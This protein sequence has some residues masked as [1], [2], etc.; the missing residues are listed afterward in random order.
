MRRIFSI[1]LGLSLLICGA[2][3]AAAQDATDEKKPVELNG[4]VVEYSVDGNVVTASGNVVIKH[5]QADMYCDTVSFDRLNNIANAKGN[6]RLVT[7]QGEITANELTFDFK[8]MKG[9]FHDARIYAE[10]YYGAAR[11]ISRVSESKIV[12]EDGYVTTSDF[13]KPE[14]RMSSSR[15]EI[16]PKDKIIAKH[17]RLQV[18]PMPLV[19]LPYFRQRLDE[20]ENRFQFRPGYDKDWGFFLLTT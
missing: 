9:D 5:P 13:D 3:S 15:I 20:P 14:Y 11:K 6:V 1:V 18:G 12:M 4:D 7:E 19:Y 16:Y 10:P 2:A 8:T 17:N